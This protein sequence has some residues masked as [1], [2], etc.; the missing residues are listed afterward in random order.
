M[1]PE[2]IDWFL[3]GIQMIF[4][5]AW[6]QFVAILDENEKKDILSSYYKRL[7]SENEKTSMEAAIDWSTYESA[8]AS[9]IPNYQI[10]T[11]DEQKKGA[12]TIS[13]IEAHYFL[14]EDFT[15][16]NALLNKVDIFRHI[17][18][19]IIQGRYDVICPMKTAY[20]LHQ[21]WPEAEFHVVPD[22]GHSAIDPAIRSQLIMATE[23][24]KKIPT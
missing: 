22:A 20:E 9:L 19:E 21:V 1:R 3:H 8:C 7:T 5:E 16:E 13:K 6:D 14:N 4:P 18:T 10:I 12:L 23:E 17:P 2:E 15:G 24:M 11:T